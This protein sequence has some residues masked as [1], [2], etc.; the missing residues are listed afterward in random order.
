MP[1][2]GRRKESFSD[3]LEM[4]MG[5]EILKRRE[6]SCRYVEVLKSFVEMLGKGFFFDDFSKE[7]STDSFI[8]AQ[9]LRN[10]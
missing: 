2:H 3:V 5:K 7:Q 10:D 8:L 6:P 1:I 4:H 9:S